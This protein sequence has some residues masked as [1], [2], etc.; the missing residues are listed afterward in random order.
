M[1]TLQL[2][3]LIVLV[4]AQGPALNL[5]RAQSAVEQAKCVVFAKACLVKWSPQAPAGVVAVWAQS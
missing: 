2:H 1:S 3:A 5:S 4:L